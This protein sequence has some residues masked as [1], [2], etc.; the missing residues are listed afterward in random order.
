MDDILIEKA[1]QARE[2]AYAPYSGFKVGAA[3]LAQNG[4]IYTGCNVE[5]ASYGLTSCA[6][7]NAVFKAVCAGERK[8]ERLALV[9]DLVNP[10]APCGACRQVLAEFAPDLTV[11]MANTRGEKRI[12]TVRELLPYAFT[13]ADL[14]EV[15]NSYRL[16]EQK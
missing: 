6:E 15:S 8:F 16:I 13:P 4:E 11:I 12:T 2:H 10:A 3:L 14:K 7:R 9:T 1:R 5:N